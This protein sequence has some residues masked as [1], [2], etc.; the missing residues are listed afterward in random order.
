MDEQPPR[1]TS[2][3]AETVRTLGPLTSVGISFVLAIVMG[4]G[5]GL[6]LD[7]W[8]GSSPWGFLVFFAIGVV[9]GILNVYRAF[10]KS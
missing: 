1:K 10:G 7:R 5:I 2:T 4:A 8:L 6:A 3:L 9:A